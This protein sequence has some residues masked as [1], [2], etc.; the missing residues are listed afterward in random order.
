MCKKND[1]NRSRGK[2]KRTGEISKAEMTNERERREKRRE[3]GAKG[4]N[5]EKN[6]E[7]DCVVH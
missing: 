1:M 5:E 7:R 3:E 4:E 2:S 6:G